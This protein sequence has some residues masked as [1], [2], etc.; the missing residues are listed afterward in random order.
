LKKIFNHSS[1]LIFA[2]IAALILA[3]CATIFNGD[4]DDVNFT[5]DPNS[6]KVYINGHYLGTTPLDL[7]LPTG[8]SYMIEFKKPGYETKTAFIN[9]SVGAGWIVLDLF[10]GLIPII[11]DA[12]TGNWYGLDQDHVN[13]VLEKQQE[14]GKHIDKEGPS[15][16][17]GK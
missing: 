14:S 10:G 13:A 12:A 17:S 2:V 1:I 11:V 9:N 6:A 8:A 15:K 4:T 5:S 3:S 7:P 16:P